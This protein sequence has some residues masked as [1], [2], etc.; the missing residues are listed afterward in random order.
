MATSD[1]E[2]S[3][4]LEEAEF[5]GQA[6]ALQQAFAKRSRLHDKMLWTLLRYPRIFEVAN[7]DHARLGVTFA[8]LTIPQLTVH[9]K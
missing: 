2:L 9:Q 3:T 7:T 8:V 6:E 1:T 5:H 4:I